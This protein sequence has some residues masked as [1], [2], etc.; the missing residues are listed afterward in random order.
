MA[1]EGAT[2]EAMYI[3][4]FTDRGIPLENIIGFAS[5]GCNVMIGSQNSV[6]SR[7]RENLPGIFIFKCM[8]MPFYAFVCQ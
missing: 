6:A 1:A 7:L 8:Y 2:A 4:K 3:K 5:D